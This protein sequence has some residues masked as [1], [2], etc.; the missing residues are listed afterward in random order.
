MKTNLLSSLTK[1]FPDGFNGENL[2]YA[3]LLQNE[4]FSFQIAFKSEN[5]NGNIE[6]F[7]VKVESDLDL[8]L[9][10]QKNF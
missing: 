2:S 3:T 4:P 10:K 5:I 6:P 1:V 9:M 8:D 7:Y